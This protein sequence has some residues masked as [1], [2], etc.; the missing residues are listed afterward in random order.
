MLLE[1]MLKETKD[2]H[3]S[4][5]LPDHLRD[6]YN[7]M[8]EEDDALDWKEIWQITNEYSVNM[9][10]YYLDN[11]KSYNKGTIRWGRIRNDIGYIQI[12]FMMLFSNYDVPSDIEIDEYVKE[13]WECAENISFSR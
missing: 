11:Y 8:K 2:K 4:I 13:Y 1:E 9:L 12:N 5:Q 7:N 6:S 10:E 3:V